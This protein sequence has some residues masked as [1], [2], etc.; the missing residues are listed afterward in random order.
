MKINVVHTINAFTALSGG[1]SSCTYDLL[2]ALNARKDIDAQII[3]TKAKDGC[4]MTGHGEA[5]II[6]V[7][8]DERTAF[9]ISANLRK[10]LEQTNADIYH[11]NGLWRYCNHAAAAVARKKHKPYVITPHGM[12]YP[13]AIAHSAWQKKLLRIALFDR[14]ISNAACIHV[15]C[16]EE[17]QHIRALG[18]T[19]P[20]A[21]IANPVPMPEIRPVKR[22]GK[23]VFGYLGRL[24]PRKQVERI[25]EAMALLSADE[26]EQC[27]LL[28][29]GA[30]EPEYEAF[31][32]E[33]V[34]RRG[35][36]NVRFAGFVEGE[37]KQRRLAELSALFVPSDFENFGMIIAEAL[38]CGTP[39]FANT[40]T[41]W[42]ILNDTGCG[43]WRDATPGNMASIMRML[44]TMEPENIDEMGAIGRQ[45][46][47]ERFS[48]EAV[49]Q[50]MNELYQWVLTRQS[51]PTFIYEYA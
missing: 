35:L 34:T 2:C 25:I 39:V 19:N 46:V 30:G 5:W 12:L 43:W 22:S 1:T 11:T 13:Q 37:E 10:A 4:P 41:P 38:S 29:M 40:T 16:E 28:I 45:L 21:V 23:A 7:E 3:A 50:Q 18:F 42:K 17:M 14:D 49:A 36:S 24:H 32:H 20:V 6:P 31:L 15:T 48:A 9:G 51:K 27:N 33:E 26:Q 44:L 47:A 8:N